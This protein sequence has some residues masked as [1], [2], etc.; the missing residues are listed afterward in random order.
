MSP[1]KGD[2]RKEVEFITELFAIVP[3]DGTAIAWLCTYEGDPKNGD[4]TGFAHDPKTPLPYINGQN[5]S[6]VL[7][8]SGQG[9]KED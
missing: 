7:P 6:T 3:D 9:R 1:G 4:W 2:G 5:A 8:P